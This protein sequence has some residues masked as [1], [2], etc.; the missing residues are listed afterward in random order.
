MRRAVMPGTLATFLLCLVIQSSS[1][2]SDWP[3]YRGPNRNGVDTSIKLNPLQEPEEVWKTNVGQGR[4]SAV[5]VAGKL[6]VLG[7]EGRTRKVCC[8][9]ASTGRLLWESPM[10]AHFADSTPAV[11]DG[12]VY[13]IG[14]T[15]E[16]KAY[17]FDAESGDEMWKTDLPQDSG[18]VRH[19]GHSGSPVVTDELVIFNNGGGAA[20]NRRTGE[21]VWEHDGLA[22]LATPVLF[23]HQESPAVAIFSGDRLVA[24]DLK[25]GRELWALPWKTNL[26][27][28]AC[29]P[30]I[31]DDSSK[32]F[33]CSDYGLGRALYDLSSGKPR[34]VWNLTAN[35]DGHAYASGFY[36][37]GGLYAFVRSF[38][39]MN[40]ADGSRGPHI[41]GGRSALALGDKV[42][43]LTSNGGLIIGKNSADGFEELVRTRVIEGETP[44][45][46]AYWNGHLYVRS[47]DGDLVCV[48]ISE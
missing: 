5:I 35:G 32:L 27:V 13:A 17:C 30:V 18:G 16:P 20:V 33:I 23:E 10:I 41:G 12:R 8:R 9:D 19:Y 43:L 29:D 22:G 44:N 14:S 42:L 38:H 3:F 24:R 31:F 21:V 40:V 47:Q 26:A 15:N 2:A 25:S 28:N 1:V 48:R 6:Y 46:P 11:V 4:G 34:E 7:R 45:V 39:R 37:N 36:L